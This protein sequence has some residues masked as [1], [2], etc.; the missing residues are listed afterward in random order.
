MARTL[1]STWGIT[2]VLTWMFADAWTACAL[3]SASLVL[4]STVDMEEP[5]TASDADTVS[6][7]A[8]ANGATS[9]AAASGGASAGAVDGAAGGAGACGAARTMVA[10]WMM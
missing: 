3:D 10:G 8:G 9:G 5:T 7:G 2:A 1:V 4:S 6:G